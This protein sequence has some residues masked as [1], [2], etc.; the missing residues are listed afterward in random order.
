[1]NAYKEHPISMLLSWMNGYRIIIEPAIANVAQICMNSTENKLRILNNT[2]AD[3]LSD[4]IIH[5][6]S[7]HSTMMSFQLSFD[8]QVKYINTA[9]SHYSDKAE[10]VHKKQENISKS[11]AHLQDQMAELKLF[12]FTMESNNKKRQKQLVSAMRYLIDEAKQVVTQFPT[13]STPYERSHDNVIL[14]NDD[15]IFPEPTLQGNI[16]DGDFH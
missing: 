9:L 8:N 3:V 1:M 4:V 15:D 5:N 7:L 12:I 14:Y 6:Q 13:E 11:L 2:V 10:K 16:E